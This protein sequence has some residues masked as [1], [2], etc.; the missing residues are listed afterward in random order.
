MLCTLL[1]CGPT[2]RCETDAVGLFAEDGISRLSLGRITAFQIARMFAH[3]RD[4]SLP[5]DFD[6]AE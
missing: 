1:D 3:R 6:T 2:T 5:T 4:P